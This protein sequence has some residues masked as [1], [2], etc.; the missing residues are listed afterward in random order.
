MTDNIGVIFDLDGVLIDSSGPHRDSWMKLANELGKPITDEQFKQ[1]FGR[2]NRDIIPILFGDGYSNAEM[3][4]LGERKEQY[5]R[6]IVGDRLMIL[7]GGVELARAC[8]DADI[9]CAIGSSGHPL[10]I[11]LAIDAM[12]IADCIVHVVT[13]HDVA[14]GKPHPEVFLKAAAGLKREPHHCVVI[15]DAPAGI[16]AAVDGGMKSIAVTTEHPREKLTA[17]NLIVDS[18]EEL[19]VASLRRLIHG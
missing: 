6:D 19:S 3:D 2:Q 13:G 9:P 1:T 7:P 5:Y 8:R 4:E 11:Q 12:G 16:N 14:I 10:N 17:A 18:L 15:E